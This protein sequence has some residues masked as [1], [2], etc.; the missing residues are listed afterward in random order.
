MFKFLKKNHNPATSGWRRS[1]VDQGI[2]LTSSGPGLL[3]IEPLLPAYLSQLLDDGHAVELTDGMLIGWD[4]L[5]EVLDNP[6]Y[7]NLSTVLGLPALTSARVVLRSTNS[8]TD[9]NF[10]IA[11]AGWQEN[12]SAVELRKTLGAVMIWD[13]SEVLM[14]SAQWKLTKEVVAFARRAA[15]QRDDL[16]HRQAWGHIRK[17][18][19][20]ANAKVDDF[21]QRSVVLTPERL[22]IALRK[23]VNI[24]DDNVIEIEPGF[25]GAPDVW[26][27]R[28][29]REKNVLDRYDIATTD[30]I[31]QILITPQVKTVL[32]EI[33][34]L[35]LRRVAGSRA[36]AFIL[37]PYAVLGEDAKDVIV[38]E[39]FERA[40]VD[41][42]LLYE[43]FST[44]VDRDFSGYPIRVGLLIEVA[45]TQGPTASET[46]WLTDEALA[47]FVQKFEFSLARGFQIL[48]WQG[49]DFELQGDAK[50]QLYELKS[51]LEERTK[52]R[53]LVWYAKVHDLR[54]Y[55]DRIE[56]IGIEEPYYSPYIAKK[57]EEDGWFPE[58]IV[59]VI[60]Y[61][62]EGG[63]ET[64]AVPLT[65]EA[66][67]RLEIE[68]KAARDAGQDS[69][70]VP[71]LPT[72]ILLGEAEKIVA[73]HEAATRDIERNRFDPDM[74]I[75]QKAEKS[76]LRKTLI[77][78]A[79]IQTVEY[80]EARREALRALPAQPKLPNSLNLE[81][82]LLPHQLEGVAWLEHLY[83]SRAEHNVRG[84]LLADDMGLGKT[85]QLLTFMSW[86]IEQ[87]P[88]IDP[89]LVV[90]PVSLLE[91][92][93]EEA[94]KF[95]QVGAFSILTAYGEDLRPLRVPRES[96]EAKLKNE[97]GLVRFLKPNWVGGAKV[98]LTT[99]ETLRD[100]EFS[101][102]AERWSVMVCDEAQRIKNPA[103]M[104]TR[105]S[106]K[107]NV[108]FK[109][110]CTG[111]PVENTLADLWC[112][113]DFIQPG[114][115]GALDEFGKRYRKPIEAKTDEEK[116]RVEDLRKKIAPQILRRTK[117]EVAKD[118]PAKIV[119]EKCRKIP[120]SIVQRNLYS[121][122]VDDFK[123][124]NDPASPSPFKNHL[125]LL[126]Y[127]RLLCTDPRRH[128]ITVFKPESLEK[129]RAE[130]PKLD[131]LLTQLKEIQLSGEKVI[132][133]CEF[134]NIQRLLQ[135]Y[136]E[137]VFDIRPDIINGD[138]S[139]AA[140]HTA[141]R[142]KRIKAFQN[143]AGF[144]VIILSPVAVGFGV[145]I[146]GANH[147]VHYTRT[148]NPAKEDQAT[149]RAYRIGQ[150]KDVYVYYP[151]VYAEDFHTFDVKLDQ[152]LTRKR[153]LASDMLNGAGDISPGD[154]DIGGIVPESQTDKIDERI[155]IEIALR[156]DWR[157]FEGLAAALWSKRGF[158]YS[159]CTPSS[160]DNGVDVVAISEA[161][162][163]LIQTKTSG[164]EGMKLGWETVKEV[165]GGE[166]FYRR[167]H[168]SVVFK[169]VG[170]TNQFFNAH[171]HEQAQLNK[172]ELIEQPKLAELLE[173]YNVTMLDV[174]RILYS[175]W[176]QG[177]DASLSQ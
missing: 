2:L 25:H 147:V 72:P 137:E 33:K 150:T 79:N 4:S 124:R 119:D 145:N 73:T 175:E 58:N 29:D 63:A 160:G 52:P 57:K 67:K 116:E 163:E 6:S 51:A 108:G 30:G 94:E 11:V 114:L 1:W 70:S 18:A 125:G 82:T 41:A 3:L 43:R 111:T 97:D 9:S 167:R 66:L 42:N 16:T 171:A 81:Y 140:S 143:K 165:V 112:L 50:T 149:D 75:A 102:A 141:S 37:N 84:A 128:G 59:P 71:W 110:A 24:A 56:G 123:K 173:R 122:A 20:H 69:V 99:Y 31:V 78:R 32:S 27:E 132:V 107:Q 158:S 89:M 54:S 105:A 148:W 129:Y 134:R 93:K 68:T 88:C 159:Y 86:L 170:L 109:I 28:F 34:R 138:T 40:R 39:Q 64:V 100:L 131:W 83:C 101:F 76:N 47:A 156:M 13:D 48:G 120:L 80:E 49:F 22:E 14:T 5:Y 176:A 17:L 61:T 117:A 85:F 74:Q 164:T 104:V 166:A 126:H 92:W 90:A 23:S 115:L 62:P 87:D 44:L 35:P 7:A 60:V 146:Q 113:F 45:D 152:L 127:L 151:V 38:E 135:H 144:G 136:I 95:F 26:L 174:E 21:L 130:A 162:G 133:F 169:K 10:S 15:E 155:D 46:R 106:K 91:N 53:T 157:Y 154:F 161:E 8:L 172:V 19:L 121:T 142:Q 55:S 118:L 98:V 36:Q 168:S 12:G 103:A 139:A 177:S 65:K 153:E 77:L 96:V